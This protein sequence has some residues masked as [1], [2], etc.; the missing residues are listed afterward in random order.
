MSVVDDTSHTLRPLIWS[1][2]AR[3]TIKAASD[4]LA[5]SSALTYLE[6]RFGA[7]SEIVYGCV[8]ATRRAAR[9]TPLV[10]ET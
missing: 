2:G 6:R 9:G 7:F 10:I 1:D 3:V 5:L 4:A 8:D